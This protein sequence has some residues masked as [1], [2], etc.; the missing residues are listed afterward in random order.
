[1]KLP[2][3]PPP[4]VELLDRL[5]REEPQRLAKILQSGIRSTVD[6]KYRSWD[7]LRQLTPP[8]GLG[9]E[10]WW[11]GIK[12]ARIS[13]MRALPLTAPD[14][15]PF[16]FMLPD[17]AHRMLAD[18]DKGAGGEIAVTE[19]VATPAARRRYLVSSLIEEAVT[20]SQLEGASTTRRVAKEMIKSGRQP[21]THSERMV[22]NNYRAMNLVRS[23]AQDDL[24]VGRILELHRT[25]TEGTLEHPDAAGRFQLPTDERV[26]VADRTDGG[27]LH[28][29]P[30]ADQ[31]PQ[32]VAALCDWA[33]GKS[34]DGFIHPVVRAIVVHLWLAYDHPFEDGNGRTARAL[35][36]WAMLRRDYWLAEFLS[37]SRILVRAPSK[38]A[39]S[40]LHTEVDD[41]DATYF[42]LY[43]LDV[44]CR[45]MEDLHEYLRRKMREDRDTS[46][47]VRLSNLNYRQIALLTHALR[48]PD[49]GFTYKSHMASHRV[50]HESA[51]QDLL[52]L[53]RRGLLS[54]A[55]VGREWVFTPVLDAIERLGTASTNEDGPVAGQ[56]TL[57][58]GE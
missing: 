2:L 39:R 33:N 56:L 54:R 52:S 32:R 1:M 25:V 10:D 15:R 48:H 20:S 18:I 12:L 14:G 4:F 58:V 9:H 7:T 34:G 30:P 31:L 50:A 28:R 47:L 35:F 37:V 41:F 57:P 53:E 19:A 5:P 17:D 46:A 16:T 45:A 43:Q 27:V 21:R 55:R 3:R 13:A 24:T 6:G 42:I 38:Y 26:V 36:Y 22:L 44:I 51:R 49:A 23:W 11:V 29:P 40:F 8:D